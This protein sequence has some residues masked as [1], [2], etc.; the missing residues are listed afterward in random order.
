MAA[1]RGFVQRSFERFE[2]QFDAGAVLQVVELATVEADQG[3]HR[4]KQFVARRYEGRCGARVDA[5]QARVPVD[6]AAYHFCAAGQLKSNAPQYCGAQ[7]RS[8]VALVARARARARAQ[9][10][11][12]G[13]VERLGDSGELG[14]QI[15]PA[16]LL[17]QIALRLLLRAQSLCDLD[18]R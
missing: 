12:F 9:P 6:F 4:T 1:T 11:A 13:D 3:L 5:D 14:Y 10:V 8:R 7:A 15:E 16:R 2:P 18:L 17:P